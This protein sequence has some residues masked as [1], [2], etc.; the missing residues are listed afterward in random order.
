MKTKIICKRVLGT[1][2]TLLD[3]PRQVL[4]HPTKSLNVFTKVAPKDLLRPP[5][6]IPDDPKHF[7]QIS[8]NWEILGPSRGPDHQAT[9]GD[10][11]VL[12]GGAASGGF[13]SA[14]NNICKQKRYSL[15]NECIYWF[16]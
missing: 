8:N 3:L 12:A 14:E 16:V 13:S 1:P 7:K 15:Q 11:L 9:E 2:R 4:D 10:T 5:R 6:R